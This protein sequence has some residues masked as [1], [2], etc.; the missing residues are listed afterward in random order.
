M[1]GDYLVGPRALNISF[2]STLG[3]S[4]RHRMLHFDELHGV[5]VCRRLGFW[6]RANG[7][8]FGNHAADEFEYFLDVAF[9]SL[10]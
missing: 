9:L 8:E 10:F 4:E 1:G 3:A 7:V 2:L 6:G 5:A